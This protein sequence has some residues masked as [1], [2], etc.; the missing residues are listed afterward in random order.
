[1]N[2]VKLKLIPNKNKLIVSSSNERVGSNESE[3][4]ADISGEGIEIIFNYNYLIDG[5]NSVDSEEI[6][7]E[8]VNSTSPAIIKSKKHPSYLYLVM[9]IQ[10]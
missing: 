8:M 6:I 1:M 3:I 7:L 5:I 4:N 9:P 2:D 10:S